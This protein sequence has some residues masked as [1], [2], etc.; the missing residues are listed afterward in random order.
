MAEA[1]GTHRHPDAG[2]V[3]PALARFPARTDV[4]DPAEI[5]TLTWTTDGRLVFSSDARVAVPFRSHEALT[6]VRIGGEDWMLYTD[7]SS[8][9]VSQAAQRVSGRHESAVESAS[10]VVL[11]M[12]G[13]VLFVAGLMLYALRRGL[14]PLDAAARDI[15]ARTAS[16]LAPIETEG[17]PTELLPLVGSINGLMGRL[18]QAMSRQRSF[19]ADAAHELRTP[20]TALR[21]QLQLLQRAPDEAG[22]AVAVD[23]LQTGIDRSQRLIEKLLQV[24][25]AEPDVVARRREAVDLAALVR[26]VV[27]RMSH[28]AD[29]QQ[30]DLGAVAENGLMVEG[31]P[32]QL[33][34]LLDNLVENALRYTPAGGAVDVVALVLE[35]VP[36]LQVV[37]TGPG[38]ALAERVRVFGRF[39]R[40]P[41]AASLARDM[42]GSG[43]GLSIVR[44]IAELHDAVVSLHDGREPGGGGLEVRVAFSLGR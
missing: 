1:L 29:Q 15:A 20:V 18:A 14:V 22:R 24:A 28:R 8:N 25:R 2:A 13:V 30:I 27:A 34:V 33:A 37:D 11:P 26:A 4:A 43:L 21:L 42:G 36:T 3:D 38:I 10:K 9:G 40:G 12:F 5:V 31:D 7:V 17:V 16:S 32:E 23:E 41:D 19:L 44:A 35:G 39:Y 6:Q